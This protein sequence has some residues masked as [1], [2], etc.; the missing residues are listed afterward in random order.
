MHIIHGQ[1]RKAPLVKQLQDSTMFV[2]ELAEM[3]KDYKTQEKSY[4]NYKAFLFA[5]SQAAID[6]YTQATA[7]GSF[8]VLNCEKLKVE[9]FDANSGKTY[10]TLMMDNARLEGAQFTQG[11]PKQQPQQ[12]PS[13]QPAQQQ[14]PQYQQPAPPQSYGQKPPVPNN[15][16]N[17]QQ[18][19]YHH[20][21]S[22][23]QPAFDDTIPF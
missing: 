13:Q 12:S 20:P 1:I 11:A 22:N 23:G 14:A 21:A 5:K 19:T 10:I 9:T 16:A 18:E 4:T 6:Y 2:I 15:P 17:G 3:I 7:E 8:I